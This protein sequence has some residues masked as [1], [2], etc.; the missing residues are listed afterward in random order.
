MNRFSQKSFLLLTVLV[1]ILFVFPVTARADG[2]NELTQTVDGYQVTVVFGKSAAVGE[3]QIHVFVK[4]GMNMPV[5]Q[6]DL[7]VSVVD[8]Q[9]E[10]VEVQPTVEAETMSGMSGMAAQPTAEV[11]TMSGMSAMDMQPTAEAGAMSGMSGMN[12]QPVQTH[13]QMI[14]LAAGSQSGE[15]DGQISI[16]SEGDLILRVHITVA[17]K[18]TEVDIPMHVAKSNTGPIVLGSFFVVNA[19]LIAAAV[20][21]K[22]KP[23]SFAGLSK[24]A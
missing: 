22:P 6:A 24:K 10:H 2:G 5:S 18:L 23:L 13:A 7:D 21:L 19:A 20:V 9:V 11:E 1:L 12:E 17:G 4:D 8:L 14:S 15:Y 16:E 3:N